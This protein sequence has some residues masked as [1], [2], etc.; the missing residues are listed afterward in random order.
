MA[1]L[2]LFSLFLWIPKTFPSLVD[3]EDFCNEDWD[4]FEGKFEESPN[5]VSND[6]QLESPS[7]M[8]EW[9]PSDPFL[10]NLIIMDPTIRLVTTPACRLRVSSICMSDDRE[11]LT[12][13]LQLVEPL[14]EPSVHKISKRNVDFQLYQQDPG[15]IFEHMSSNLDN[16]TI[17]LQVAVQII[18]MVELGKIQLKFKQKIWCLGAILNATK[19]CDPF[20]LKEDTQILELIF[21]FTG[22]IS[23]LSLSTC[24]EET[25]DMVKAI[26][27]AVFRIYEV[28]TRQLLKTGD[29]PHYVQHASATMYIVRQAPKELGGKVITIPGLDLRCVLPS[30]SAL[31]PFMENLTSVSLE[32][33]SFVV[34]PFRKE[35]NET[36][37]GRIC[38]L[39]LQDDNEKEIRLTNL[40]E[41][42]Q[43]FMP[44]PVTTA[45][46]F[47]PAKMCPCNYFWLMNASPNNTDFDHSTILNYEAD[48]RW[49]ITPEMLRI[50]LGTWYIHVCLVNYTGKAESMQLGI[51]TFLSKCLFW[52]VDNK[53]WSTNG[54]SVGVKSEPHL[55][56]CL[57]NHLTFLGSSFFVMPNN[58]DL[59]RTAEYFARVHENYVVVVL[60][61]AFF[62]VY[63]ILLFWAIYADKQ[64]F[65][66]KKMT[67]LVDN[68]PCA[69]YFYLLNVQTGHRRG[70]GTTAQVELTLVGTEGQSKCRHLA[71]PNKPL[72]ERGGV[73]MFLLATPFS[74]GEL[75]SIRLRHDNSGKSPGWY[76][77]KMMVQDMQTRMHWHFLCS[78]WLSSTKGDCMTK[79]T[80]HSAKTTEITS[81]RNIFQSRTSSGFRDEHIW[82][83]VVD[84]PRR[85]PF[86]RAQRVSCCMCLL[87]C[88]MAINILFW[89]K[90]S[91]QESPVIF[92]MGS[93]H[94]TWEDIMIGVES[95]LLMFP[96]NILIITIFR[97]IRPRLDKPD[98][99]KNSNAQDQWPAA[100]MATLLQDTEE[101]VTILSKNEKNNV[102]PLEKTLES[103]DDLCT[104]LNSVQGLIKLIQ[105]KDDED[106]HWGHCSLFLLSYLSHLWDVLGQV[107]A[108]EFLSA[109]DHQWTQSTLALLHKKAEALCNTRTP[110]GLISAPKKKKSSGCW[111]PWWFVFVGWFLLFSISGISTFF[112][113][114]YGFVYGK[115]SSTQWAISLALSL[116]QSI[117][118]LQPLKVV[119]LAI[120]FALVL[121]TVTV[122]ESEEVEWLLKE[123]REKCKSYSQ[124][125]KP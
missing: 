50:G 54:C 124:G 67:L 53:T 63:L 76:L 114:L 9:E 15:P 18:D 120:F 106:D 68:H 58:V 59:S 42:I 27:D 78:T 33:Y 91:D 64:A 38:S 14:A 19:L 31:G 96:I 85:S 26:S 36:V 88:T 99:Q 8:K 2:I 105:G 21:N 94:V 37:S 103:F 123:Q 118:I 41:Q 110:R 93:L 28:L 56:Q 97:S 25:A 71:D 13:N 23:L 70:A 60:L 4:L 108:R 20:R 107:K 49:L 43:V 69:Q 86:T 5:L 16:I 48:F 61:S 7:D 30:F 90:P 66:K 80:F 10:C 82:V 39:S 29:G 111:L 95:G 17:T 115:E 112:T 46:D 35:S 74:L 109:E 65:K 51:M 57:C 55:T 84:P 100:T 73:D 47:N 104:A 44:R 52:D 32:M 83:S 1:F 45:L 24:E 79:K 121:K 77:Y 75:E 40:T 12:E 62:G 87:L 81:F 34:N 22:V 92:S 72:F 101:L 3:I 117:F 125:S 102:P 98:K 11:L 116:F 119:G 6:S 89:N 113:L 122:E